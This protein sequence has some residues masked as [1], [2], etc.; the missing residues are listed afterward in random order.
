MVQGVL[1]EG[2]CLVDTNPANGEV[3]AR[4]PCSTL[5]EVAVA[6]A[7]AKAAQPAWAATPLAD[8]IAILKRGCALLAENK[9]EL[10]SLA[11]KEMGKVRA[12]AAEEVDGAAN[13]ID[14]LDLVQQ[15]NEA[16]RVSNGLIVRE[17][18][19]VVAVLSPWNFPVDEP[20]LLA[21]P[22]LAAG[23]C[24][25]LKPS[26]VVPLCGAAVAAALQAVLPPGVLELL[27]GDGAVGAALVAGDVHMCAMTGSSAVGKKIMAG[28]APS[29]KRLV[30]ELGGKDP[31]VVFADADLDHAANDAVTFSLFN[32]GQVCCSVERVYVAEAV[33]GAFEEKCAALVQTYVAGDG[34]DAGSK[35]G[36][37]VSA[38]QRDL[39]AAQVADAV[40]RGARVVAQ[41]AVPAGAAGNWFPATLVCGAAQD[42]PIQRVETFGPVVVVASFDGTE[43]EG[44][45]LANDTEYGLAAYVY[46]TDMQKAQRVALGIKAGQVGINNW[47]LSCAPAE[48]PW[49]GHKNSGM[50][51]HSGA[52]GWRQFSNPK[53]LIFQT[54]EDMPL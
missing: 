26:E 22:A 11:V 32:T 23:N 17:A 34:F 15:A 37:M 35:I 54:K 44:V 43:A 10:V 16:Q 2:G 52:D 1:I 14:W 31:M 47:S 46:T 51:Y 53:S 24:V 4:V 27:Q 8:R 28:C 48:C 5:A 38:T 40:S 20:L 41:G 50:G 12:E 21:L 33:R 29:L 39:V 36:P 30:L 3:I 25:C 7:R 9:D 45:R 6:V 49:V 19:G 13:K 18:H 42:M